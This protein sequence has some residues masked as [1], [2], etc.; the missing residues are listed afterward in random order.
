MTAYS[1]NERNVCSHYNIVVI[2]SWNRGIKDHASEMP[3]LPILSEP[4]ARGEAVRS[5]V[6]TQS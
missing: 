2:S 1:V 4:G 6:I 5:T 3:G